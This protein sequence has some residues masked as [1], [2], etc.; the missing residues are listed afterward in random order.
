MAEI[1][2]ISNKNKLEIKKNKLT[3]FLK[4]FVTLRSEGIPSLFT[5]TTRLLRAASSFKSFYSD[6]AQLQPAAES[7]QTGKEFLLNGS[8]RK[9][10]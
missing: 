1:G 6:P 8:L 3:A 7:F 10:P 2:T 9:V 5:H 4:N